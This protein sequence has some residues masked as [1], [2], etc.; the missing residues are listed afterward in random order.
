MH[1]NVIVRAYKARH[2]KQR[3]ENLL[4]AFSCVPPSGYILEFGVGYGHSLRLLG[5]AMPDREIYAFDSF[6]GL[7]EDWIMS[8][9]I[10]VPAG[11]WKDIV[12]VEYDN[13]E[14]VVGLFADTLPEWKKS[15]TAS[16]AF[17]HIDCDL[18]SSTVTVLSELNEQIVPGTILAFDEI[19][20]S[21]GYK[22]WQDGEYKAFNEWQETHCRNV[23]ELHR[24]GFGE[25]VFCVTK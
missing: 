19:Y 6:C 25:A 1:K 15:N 24:T 11:T 17:M 4:Y 18:Y 13:V 23:R 22:N 3:K 14:Y 8:E 9:N 2:I 16:I 7:P 21:R 20:E 10:V 5:E 12:P